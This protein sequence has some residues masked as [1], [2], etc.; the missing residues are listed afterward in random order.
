MA[1]KTRN[2][3]AGRGARRAQSSLEFVALF[4]VA[5]A[6]FV[7]L[8]LYL[9]NEKLVVAEGHGALEARS[10]ARHVASLITATGLSSGNSPEFSVPY[11]VGGMA[12]NLTV[13]NDSV[14]VDWAGGSFAAGFAAGPVRNSTASA[15]FRLG[16]GNHF[17]NNTAGTVWVV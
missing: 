4:A 15:P 11:A 3:S 2:R 1:A 5:L 9:A 17:V 8:Y 16:G 7:L 6:F 12:N 14:W 10:L 13:T